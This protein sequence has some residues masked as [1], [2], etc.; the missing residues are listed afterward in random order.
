MESL[1]FLVFGLAAIPEDDKQKH[2]VAGAVI[3]EVAHQSGLTPFQS[4]GIALAAGIA[5]EAWDFGGRGD[6]ELAD[7][8]ATTA[9]CGVTFRF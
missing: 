4:C 9:G 2:F 7:A 6:V 3:S 1:V 5:K 8:I